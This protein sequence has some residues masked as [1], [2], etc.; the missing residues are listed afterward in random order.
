MVSKIDD[1]KP[2]ILKAGVN[3]NRA[4]ASALQPAFPLSGAPPR[5]MAHRR[6]RNKKNGDRL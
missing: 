2:L 3:P 4:A 5:R 6:G 1:D